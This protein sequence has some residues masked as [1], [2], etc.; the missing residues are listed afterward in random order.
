VELKSTRARRALT[1]MGLATVAV[2]AAGAVYLVR[3]ASHLSPTPTAPPRL[4]LVMASFG[5]ADHGAVTMG[6]SSS[7][8]IYETSNGGRTWTKHQLGALT[9][10]FLDRDHAVAWGPGQLET[11]ADSGQT[12]RSRQAPF[13]LE[14]SGFLSGAGVSV[15]PTF[16]DPMNVWWLDA[17][18]GPPSLWRSIDGGST[19]RQLA[20]VGVHSGQTLGQPV[21][22]D[23][24]RG[25]IVMSA[26]GTDS[27]PSVLTTQDAGESWREVSL[28]ESPMEGAHLALP[29]SL[30]A[31]LLAHDGDL[32][33]S[34]STLPPG[35]D[36]SHS[37]P[38]PLGDANNRVVS[39]WSSVSRDG[40]QTWW[41]WAAEPPLN[42]S[43]LSR[44]GFDDTGR[45]LLVDD[46]RLWISSDDG[47][48]W[49]GHAIQ[50]PAGERIVALFSAR[51]GALFALAWRPGPESQRQGP[52]VANSGQLGLLRSRDG[53]TRW[54]NVALPRS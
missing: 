20:G 8:A 13:S 54:I 7:P 37:V 30:A 10:T 32:V 19:W 53:G 28:P 45:L 2:T 12:W 44:K 47:R 41:P 43:T 49:Q 39:H 3:S 15:G 6:G 38:G 48:T 14:S 36:R 16:L 46:Q 31:I 33:L 26:L 17:G 18:P 9:I 35:V 34:L 21:F 51:G 29:T 52:S 50:M 11:T 23:A 22:I 1:L 25:G 40:G 42:L 5:D 27:W 24:L 4:Q